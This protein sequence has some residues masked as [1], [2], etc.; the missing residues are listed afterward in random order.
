[1]PH[2]NIKYWKKK[3][4]RNKERDIL[5][6][7]KLEENGWVVLRIWEHSLSTEN[8]LEEWSEKISNLILERRDIRHA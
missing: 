1:M 3:I 7:Q 2:S 5:T 8:S 6:T 4:E